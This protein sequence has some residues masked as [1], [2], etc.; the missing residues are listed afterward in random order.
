[1]W[2]GSNRVRNCASRSHAHHRPAGPLGPLSSR[3]VSDGRHDLAKYNEPVAARQTANTEPRFRPA[4]WI[5]RE[6]PR[7]QNVEV[8]AHRLWVV[9]IVA[10]VILAGQDVRQLRLTDL[11]HQF[12]DFIGTHWHASQDTHLQ[13]HAH[14]D[15]AEPTP[16]CH[17]RPHLR[18]RRSNRALQTNSDVYASASDGGGPRERSS[19]RRE[20]GCSSQC[21]ALR[22][23]RAR[24]TVGTTSHSGIRIAVK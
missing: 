1:V 3:R 21:R 10:F 23:A 18:Q 8:S 24:E 6:C 19:E 7:T 14:Q 20:T 5:A 4:D 13:Y 16:Y 9:R 12:P 22:R 11:V 17:D 15:R 2:L